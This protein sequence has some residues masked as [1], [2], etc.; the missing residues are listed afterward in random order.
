MPAG[1]HQ[2]LAGVGNENHVEL[3][4]DAEEFGKLVRIIVDNDELTWL[5]LE[6]FGLIGSF[7]AKDAPKL[8]KFCDVNQEHHIVTYTSDHRAMNRYVANQRVYMLA[9]GDKNPYLVLNP[10]IDPR[11]PLIEEDLFSKLGC[12]LEQI[13]RRLKG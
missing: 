9:L 4:L 10:W 11:R 8:L 5:G 1:R 13:K 7:R 3:M 2:G 6:P 12:E